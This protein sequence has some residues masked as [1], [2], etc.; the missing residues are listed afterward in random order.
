MADHEL[1]VGERLATEE[2]LTIVQ[3]LPTP[4]PAPDDES[5]VESDP[6]D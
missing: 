6:E 3:D 1:E 2:E 5:D 4:P